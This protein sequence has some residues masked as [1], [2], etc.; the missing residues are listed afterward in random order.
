M[1]QAVSTPARRRPRLS[2][3]KKLLFAALTTALVLTLL[4]V[5]LRCF[6]GWNQDWLD[7]HRGHSVLGWCLREGWRGDQPWTGGP[8]AINPQGLRD[9]A[10]VGP[11]TAGE[12]R[13]LI[14]GDSVTFGATVRTDEAYPQRLEQALHR[15]GR[16]WRVL[17]AGVTSYDAGQEA[18]WLD[19]FGWQTEPEVIAVAFC[20]NDL[21]P[22]DRENSPKRFAT[23]T[24]TRWLTEHS[25]VA[26]YMERAIWLGR[27]K[28]TQSRPRP[29][30]ESFDVIEKPY[31]QIDASARERGLPV[32]LLVFPTRELIEGR[33]HDDYSERL[34]QLGKELGWRVIDLAPAFPRDAGSLFL[35][36]DMVHP[37]A[38]GYKLVAE[39]LHREITQRNLLP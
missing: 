32:I 24:I 19:V 12:K 3:R 13:L 36:G 23:G 33:A 28:I 8:S 17:N 37:N 18:D 1:S 5:G 2:L 31:R 39:Y 15:D 21:F 6:V 26:F 34:E 9:D 38:E 4:E 7:C 30:P 22:S 11:K 29:E 27:A 20:R 25:A 16:T 35:S 14:L 10:P